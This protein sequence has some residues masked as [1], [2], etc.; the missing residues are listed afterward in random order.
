MAGLTYLYIDGTNLFAGLYDLFGGKMPRFADILKQIRKLFAIDKI[1]FYATYLGPKEK[2]DHKYKSLI[3]QEAK[4]YRE[5]KETKNIIF[6][7]G[8]RSPTSGREKGVDVHLCADIFKDAI[9]KKYKQSLIMSGDADLSYPVE[10]ITEKHIPVHA[11]FLSN[12][13]SLSISIAAT[14]T[15]ILNCKNSFPKSY[16]KAIRKNKTRIIDCGF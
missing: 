15:T 11:V 1:F 5:V 4:F 12:R 16:F 14:S 3:T 10:L 9:Y 7:K 8:H 2:M 6:Y 13:F